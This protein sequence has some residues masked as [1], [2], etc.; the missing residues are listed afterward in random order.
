MPPSQTAKNATRYTNMLPSSVSPK[1]FANSLVTSSRVARLALLQYCYEAGTSFRRDASFTL[2][3][4]SG[5]ESFEMATGE[6]DNQG[7]S[8]VFA[9]AAENFKMAADRETTRELYK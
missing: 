5:R 9:E 7:A 8:L 1:G 2:E 3:L 6:E 4:C